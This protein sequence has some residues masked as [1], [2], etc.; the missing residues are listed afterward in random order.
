MASWP[1]IC[2]Y[3][4][5]IN[6]KINQGQFPKHWLFQAHS[7]SPKVTFSRSQGLRLAHH[8]H[9]CEMGKRSYKERG[10][11]W[12]TYATLTVWLYKAHPPHNKGKL[13]TVSAL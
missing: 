3:E 2:C 5:Q 13:C 8:T 4:L 11:L 10:M 6:E 7:E 9:I 12:H 1:F